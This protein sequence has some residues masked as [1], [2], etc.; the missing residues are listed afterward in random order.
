MPELFYAVVILRKSPRMHPVQRDDRFQ[1]AWTP[2]KSIFLT[3]LLII[4][5]NISVMLKGTPKLD[6]AAGTNSG[7]REIC[8]R[9]DVRRGRPWRPRD[10]LGSAASASWNVDGG[11]RGAEERLGGR[12]APMLA[13][14]PHDLAQAGASSIQL[15]VPT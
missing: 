1:H 13:K 12:V 8:L 14:P 4:A 2:R 11:K 5:R 9:M 6:M 15:A 7:E 3:L 10:G